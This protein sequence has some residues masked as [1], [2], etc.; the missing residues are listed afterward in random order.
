MNVDCTIYTASKQS[1]AAAQIAVLLRWSRLLTFFTHF[2]T[3]LIRS[4]NFGLNLLRFS[5]RI[6]T[7]EPKT[8]E[9][10]DKVNIASQMLRRTCRA[11]LDMSQVERRYD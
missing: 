1:Q 10:Q 2:V 4:I 8:C 9:K 5:G 6:L 11:I 3:G 7:H